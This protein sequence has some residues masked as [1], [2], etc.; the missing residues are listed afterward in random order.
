ME[1][2]A[3][4]VLTIALGVLAIIVSAVST[5]ISSVN[6][7]KSDL[8]V[9]ES[10]KAANAANDIAKRALELALFTHKGE[11]APRLF[12]RLIVATI[13]NDVYAR[14]ALKNESRGKAI[15]VGINFKVIAWGAHISHYNLKNGSID[16]KLVDMKGNAPVYPIAIPLNNTVRFQIDYTSLPALDASDIELRTTAYQRNR[17]EVLREHYKGILTHFGACEV[18]YTDQVGTS[19]KVTLAYNTATYRFEGESREDVL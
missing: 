16:V 11:A 12:G 1:N 9:I 19:Y 18:L 3:F 5:L 15:I 10:V 6:T 7:L 2:E 14:L 17:D 13:E 4:N 8:M